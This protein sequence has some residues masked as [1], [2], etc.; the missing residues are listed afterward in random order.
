MPKSS[1]E[2]YNSTEPWSGFGSIIAMGF[3]DKVI[4]ETNFPDVNFRNWLLGQS[5]GSDGILTEE[6]IV[7]VTSIDVSYKS[8][9]SLQGIGFFV[10]LKSLTCI[11][12]QL[13][14]L[15]V[16]QNINLTYLHCGGN[17]LASLDVTKNT[18]L[19]DLY[20]YGNQLASLDVSKNT[21][22]TSLNCS[23][24]QLA[25]LDVSKNTALVTLYCSGNQLTSLEVSQNKELTKLGCDNNQIAS[26]DLAKNTKLTELNCCSNQ[27]ASLDLT[28]N[29]ALTTLYCYKNKIRGAAMDTL[30]ESLPR[31]G[32]RKM[33][34]IYYENEGNIMTTTQ[35]QAAN[36]K[37][38]LVY[39]AIENEYSS[40]NEQWL[41]YTGSEPANNIAVNE[42]NF[43]DENFRN[44]ILSKDYGSD[45]ILTDDE[46]SG[47]ES[48]T[49]LADH[50]IESLEGIGFFSALKTLTIK[51]NKLSSLDVSKNTELTSLNCNN[52]QLTTLDVSS[53]KKL[54]SLY[55]DKNQLTSLNVSGSPELRTLSCGDNQL[56]ALDASDCIS[57]Q[58]LD[59]HNNQLA[60]LDVSRCTVLRQI[61]CYQNQLRGAAMDTLVES[62]P[63]KSNS[64]TMRVMHNEV[65]RNVMTTIQVAA[66]K[67]KGWTPQYLFGGRVI[68][69]EYAGSEPALSGDVNGDSTVNGTDIQ[70]I[71]N[72]IV[73]GEYDE[74]ADVNED[75]TVNG[76]DIQEVINI[77]VGGE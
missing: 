19:K 31:G 72:V 68:W 18:R 4:D 24:N 42:A 8:I 26:L 49:I 33:Y 17:K 25:S 16:S 35:V 70:A 27:L 12:N 65:E 23:N 40:S 29:T 13:D 53:N 15:N 2:A 54:E 76:T 32:T 74:K 41:D 45:G 58:N 21:A 75:G 1:V 34:V 64:G 9:R 59:C 46:I 48:I 60:T 57:L 11:D 20:C 56:D 77:I 55:C 28:K 62:L 10:A 38:W 7:G 22:L 51:A 71:I 52:N 37:S 63:V 44:W 66:A 69:K 3:G 30:V 14:L 39:Y 61:Y 5:Y 50:N 6:E 47:I 43:P 67:D 36:A 73:A